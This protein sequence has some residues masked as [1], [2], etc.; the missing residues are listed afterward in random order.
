[1]W[2]DQKSYLDLRLS[3]AAVKAAYTEQARQIASLQASHDWLRVRVTQL[4]KERA[5]LLHNF[6]GIKVE[7]PEVV[8]TQPSRTDAQGSAAL[9]AAVAPYFTDMGDDEALKQG[10]SWNESGELTYKKS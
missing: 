4:E 10:V 2:I 1:M 8:Q 5:Q 9:A 7:V 6:M 3:E